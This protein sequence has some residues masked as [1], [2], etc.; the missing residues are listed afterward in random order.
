MT[1]PDNEKHEKTFWDYA[2]EMEACGS[3]GQIIY[4]TDPSTF[5]YEGMCDWCGAMVLQS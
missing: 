2:Q 5:A 4:P 3:C 1:T